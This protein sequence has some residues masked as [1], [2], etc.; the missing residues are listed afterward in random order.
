MSNLIHKEKHI[1]L[2]K[3]LDE[4]S[5]DF[6]RHTGKLPSDVTLMEFMTW[7]YEQTKNPTEE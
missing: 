7:A 4:L 2:H 3:N 6:I 5:A 1:E